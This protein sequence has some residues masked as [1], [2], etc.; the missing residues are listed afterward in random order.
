MKKIITFMFGVVAVVTATAQ[1][2]CMEGLSVATYDYAVKGD[3]LRLDV[4]CDPSTE[5]DTPRP[6]FLYCFGGGFEGGSRS[7]NCNDLYNLQPFMARQGYAAVSIDYRLGFKMARDRGDI[8]P[9]VSSSS[10]HGN[11]GLDDPAIFRAFYDA[12]NMAAEDLMDATSFL[13]SHAKE[14]NIDPTRIVTCGSS[15]GA[16]T[17][18]TAEY[19]RANEAE[20][21]NKHLPEGFAYA[22]VIPMAGGIWTLDGEEF[23][24]KRAPAPMMLFHGTADPTVPVQSLHL[25]GVKATFHGSKDFAEAIAKQNGTYALYL[26]EDGDHTVAGSPI[27][28]N[29]YDM[30]SFI[31]RCVNDGE[32]IQLEIFEHSNTMP[33]NMKWALNEYIP[34]WAEKNPE[35]AAAVFKAIEEAKKLIANMK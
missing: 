7:D 22:A 28:T 15:A 25:P 27:L 9:S 2:K 12:Q 1:P 10:L 24:F 11:L 4:V 5:A 20:M 13:V 8:A 18:A 3:T 31:N 23:A 29:R 26:C 21:A 19:L 14:L 34:K 35:S 17:V 16:I 30:L 32:S 6:V 33:R